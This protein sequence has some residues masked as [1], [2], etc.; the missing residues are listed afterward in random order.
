MEFN[1]VRSVKCESCNTLHDLSSNTFIAIHGNVTEGEKGG[2]YGNKDNTKVSVFCKKSNCISKL[3]DYFDVA[4]NHNN[5]TMDAEFDEITVNGDDIKED[6]VEDFS[7]EM[8]I[9]DTEEKAF[10]EEIS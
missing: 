10:D 7:S 8:I 4:E 1:V 3:L 5:D 2:I 9:N 6:D